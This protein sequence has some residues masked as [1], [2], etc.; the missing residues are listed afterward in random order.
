MDIVGLAGRVRI[1]SR[2][3][4]RFRTIGNKGQRQQVASSQVEKHRS[5]L[6]ANPAREG[7]A[8]RPVDHARTQDN[9]LKAVLLL[10]LPEQL[11]LPQLGMGIR[12][13]QL[14]VVFERRG[15]VDARAA[16]QWHHPVN[17]ERAD[18]NHASLSHRHTFARFQPLKQ[19]AGDNHRIGKQ[20]CRS[21]FQARSQMHNQRNIRYG[22]GAVR[23]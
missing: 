2:H 22:F 21:A 7:S 11:L 3:H 23:F 20:L 13:S 14:R 9:K 6:Q 19:V 5:N 18:K 10:V 12:V 1:A 16:S 15:F 8:A 17:A 4:N